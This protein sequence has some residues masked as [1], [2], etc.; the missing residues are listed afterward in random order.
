T[1]ITELKRQEQALAEARRAAEAASQA[2]SQ[3]LATMSH[4]LRT[5]MNGVIGMIYLLHADPTSADSALWLR[6]L[7][8]S[9][10]A[11]MQ[12]VGD[13]LDLSKIEADQ[14]VRERGPFAPRTV[15]EDAIR[16]FAVAAASKGLRLEFDWPAEATPERV[17][18]DPIRLRQV[19]VNLLGNAVK[20]TAR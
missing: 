14:L 17:I 11:M 16:L 7:K 6:L 19:L 20:F 18:G 8:Q 12:L 5:P 9:A 3:F 10:E 4:E 1:E 13:I 15:G 2:K